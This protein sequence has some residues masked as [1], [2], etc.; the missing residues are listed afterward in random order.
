MLCKRV[1]DIRDSEE[2]T[3]GSSLVNHPEAEV[4]AKLVEGILQKEALNNINI[5]IITFFEKQRILIRHLLRERLQ[6]ALVIF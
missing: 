2:A 3:D 4:V 6:Y 5:A 1:L